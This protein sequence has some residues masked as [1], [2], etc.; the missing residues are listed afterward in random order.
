LA[1]ALID[2]SAAAPRHIC[3][4]DCSIEVRQ[5]NIRN[6]GRACCAGIE[7]GWRKNVLIP[8]NVCILIDFDLKECF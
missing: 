7:S 6:T 4:V 8:V 2:L 3:K 1:H 5:A